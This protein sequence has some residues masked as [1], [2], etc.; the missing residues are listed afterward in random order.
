MLH[1]LTGAGYATVINYGKPG[2]PPA[3]PHHHPPG[4]PPGPH[5]PAPPRP[6]NK[7]KI[8]PP[9]SVPEYKVMTNG[10]CESHGLFELTSEAACSSAVDALG[11]K[12]PHGV[13]GASFISG[14]SMSSTC[15]A[16]FFCMP[17][18]GTGGNKVDGARKCQHPGAPTDLCW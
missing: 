8:T 18:G 9:K 6:A 14:C 10:S 1:N 3:P 16:F 11:Y 4:P 2:P 12:H 17:G 15:E 7:C 5:P 13:G